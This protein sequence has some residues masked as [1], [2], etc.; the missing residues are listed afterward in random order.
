MSQF[1]SRVSGTGSAFPARVVTNDD[2]AKTLDTNDAW[3]SERTGI[4][5][6]RI[7]QPGS[8]HEQNSSLGYQAALRALEM[9][10]K[11]VEDIDAIL[12]AT[13]SPDTLVPST[14]CW[15]QK[16]LG[17][18]KAWALDVNAACS[19]FVYALSTADMYIRNGQVKTVLV[20]GGEVLSSFVNWEDRT[21]AILFGDGAGAFIL[22]QTAADSPQRILSSHLRTDGSLWDLF[23][24]HAG[25]SNQPVTPE[26][27][28]KRLDKMT[29]KGKEIFKVA[30]KTLADF[31]EEAV[32]ANGLSLSDVDWFVPHQAN[33]RIIEAV[34]KRLEF[35]AERTLI[36]IDKFGNTSAA[37]TPTAFDEAVRDGR[38]KP[39]QVVLF[40]VFGAGLTYGS[41]LMRW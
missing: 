22:E 26:I 4:R 6:R 2:L 28:E 38:V 14:A 29:M 8:E 21:S 31:A 30:V 19:G 13:C 10:G 9:A 16:K 11:K 12:F 25:G 34:A 3:I 17:A 39:G 20:V 7:S 23:Y 37:T 24:I 33:L 27:H 35:P 41:L 5:Q 32:K 40:D 1:A 15:L 36:N 18:K